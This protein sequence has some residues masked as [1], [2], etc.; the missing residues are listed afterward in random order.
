MICVSL[1]YYAFV[2]TSIHFYSRP[3]DQ[4]DDCGVFKTSLTNE[5]RIC[6][7]SQGLCEVDIVH[8]TEN[9]N[10][11]SFADDLERQLIAA[12]IQRFQQTFMS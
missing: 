1:L 8:L 10:R 12:K 6:A 9:A 7:E 4:T 5:L 3:I 11:Y 2:Y